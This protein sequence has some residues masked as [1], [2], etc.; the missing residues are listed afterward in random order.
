MLCCLMLA[1]CACAVRHVRQDGGRVRP[2]GVVG[3][4]TALHRASEAC[5]GGR[6]TP[7]RLPQLYA[8]MCVSM[9]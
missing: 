1:C 3:A 7:H 9:R 4:Y 2:W 5:A 8:C 6:D